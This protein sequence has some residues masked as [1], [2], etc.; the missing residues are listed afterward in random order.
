MSGRKSMITHECG[1]SARRWARFNIVGLVGLLVQLACLWALTQLLNLHYILATAIAVELAILHNFC[2]HAAWTWIDRP[3]SARGLVWRLFQ[4]NVT[5]GAISIVGNTVVTA[6]LVETAHL[7]YLT[8]NLIGVAACSLANFVA[9]D[10]LVFA[11]ALAVAVAVTSTPIHAADLQSSAA[12]AF[13]RYARL[14]E[15]RM[16]RE[17]RGELPFLWAD[18][19]PDAQRRDV[20]ARVQRGDIVVSRLQTASPDGPVQFPDALCHHWVGTVFVPNTPLRRVVSLMQGYDQYATIYSPAV[21]RSR[22]LSHSDNSFKVHLQLFQQKV[23]SVVLNTESSVTYTPVTATRMQVRSISTR[24]AEVQQPGSPDEGEKPVGHDSG[25]LWR[26]N[27]YCA[28]EEAQ[29]G[30]YVQCESVSLSRDVPFGLGWLV[31]PFVTS[32]PRESL[33]FTLGAMARALKSA[34]GIRNQ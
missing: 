29:G 9:S 19:L 22:M 1:S 21:R 20:R 8:A 13:E 10:L 3:T 6:A 33:E 26:F 11:P 4:F 25:Y 24:V 30:T 31:G 18:S 7:H 28:L 5:T 34:S 27:N 32:V 17:R 16:D 15:A 12:A 23:V 14:T 2:W